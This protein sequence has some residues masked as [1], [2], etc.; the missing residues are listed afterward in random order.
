MIIIR[1]KTKKLKTQ[2]NLKYLTLIKKK[3]IFIKKKKAM[4]V[5]IVKI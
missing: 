1:I 2:V 4:K 3:M 5:I